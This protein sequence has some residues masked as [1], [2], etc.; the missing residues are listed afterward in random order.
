MAKKA[1]INNVKLFLNSKFV[2]LMMYY[3]LSFTLII[4]RFRMYRST[5]NIQRKKIRMLL[6]N[7]KVFNLK[8]ESSETLPFPIKTS[9]PVLFLL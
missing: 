8:E 5:L 4:T 9:L 2:D 7:G 6:I 3:L 1:C